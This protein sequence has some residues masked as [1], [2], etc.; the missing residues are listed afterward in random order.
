MFRIPMRQETL[1]ILNIRAARKSGSVDRSGLY[2][3][4]GIERYSRA[5]RRH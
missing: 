2:A 3:V 5:V 1:P 4:C